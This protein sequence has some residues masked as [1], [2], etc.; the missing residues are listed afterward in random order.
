MP[1]FL[2]FRLSIAAV[3]SADFW[4]GL[5]FFKMDQVNASQ[6]FP[7]ALGS[8]RKESQK[9]PNAL[10]PNQRRWTSW[11]RTSW[12]GLLSAGMIRRCTVH[13]NRGGS[14]HTQ[15]GPRE[16]LAIRMIAIGP[17]PG[18][19][20]KSDSDLDEMKTCCFAHFMHQRNN[21][22]S[23]T[24]PWS[25]I[26]TR[27]PVRLFWSLTCSWI[28]ILLTAGRFTTLSDKI[29]RHSSVV[30][31]VPAGPCS[32]CRT[33]KFSSR[34][35]HGILSRQSFALWSLYSWITCFCEA[36]SDPDIFGRSQSLIQGI[37]GPVLIGNLEG[38]LANG[39]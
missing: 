15:K 29:E 37:C 13:A 14:S 24:L 38:C 21:T 36:D 30:P 9:V 27:Y 34:P 33:P 17:Y 31:I 19:A 4:R 8:N 2:I 5:P 20:G 7:S 26:R 12:T 25:S 22:L 16:S 18:L 28:A 39:L 6:T 23:K 32:A 11:T 1:F 3:N 35:A 10:H